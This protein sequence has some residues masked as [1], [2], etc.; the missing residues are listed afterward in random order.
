MLS[1]PVIP[2]NLLAMLIRATL[3]RDML[4]D[5][6]KI[7]IGTIWVM[8]YCFSNCAIALPW[9]TSSGT[10]LIKLSPG[11]AR[12]GAVLAVPMIIMSLSLA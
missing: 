2:V 8:F 9:F 4:S 5:P 12:E 7:T 10:S 3:S 6:A 1:G 11:I